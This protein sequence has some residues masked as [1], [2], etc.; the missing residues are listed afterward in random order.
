MQKVRKYLNENVNL[1]LEL[2]GKM[3]VPFFYEIQVC[4]SYLNDDNLTFDK[5]KD[6]LV[7]PNACLVMIDYNI[8]HN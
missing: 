4:N 6:M 3:I 5:S 1:K 8:D 2:D 7:L